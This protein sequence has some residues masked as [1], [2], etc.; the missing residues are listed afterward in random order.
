VVVHA[1]Y[2]VMMGLRWL[3]YMQYNSLYGTNAH[4]T[5]GAGYASQA[6][7]MRDFNYVCPVPVLD[8]VHTYY[9]FSATLVIVP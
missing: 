1:A 3:Q 7:E 5:N 6:R 9:L 4:G 2:T 8:Y